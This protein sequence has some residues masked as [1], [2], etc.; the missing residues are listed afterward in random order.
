MQVQQLRR[1]IPVLFRVN[2]AERTM[3]RRIS[4]AAYEGNEALALRSLIREAAQRLE[5][6]RNAQ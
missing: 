4:Q 2:E 3:L 5:A 1:P 6:V